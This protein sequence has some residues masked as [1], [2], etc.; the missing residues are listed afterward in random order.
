MPDFFT[1]VIYYSLPRFPECC[2]L[3]KHPDLVPRDILL[4]NKTNDHHIQGG[5]QYDPNIENA[6]YAVCE[7][8]VRI[9]LELRAEKYDELYLLFRTRH[10]KPDNS[11]RYLVTGFYKI[12]KKFDD[13]FPIREA[14]VI[15]A[16][17]MHFVSVS[18]CIDVTEEITKARAFRCCFTSNNPKWQKQLQDWVSEISSKRNRTPDYIEEINNLK[19]LFQENEIEN[20][21]YPFCET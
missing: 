15:H 13:S 10:F 19:R 6:E 18:D 8:Q 9:G 7:P 4:C 17:E 20:R 11:S 12:E 21:Q 2:A 5:M 3:I 1:S 14:P 16:K